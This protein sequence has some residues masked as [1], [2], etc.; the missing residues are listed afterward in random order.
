VA[1]KREKLLE[2]FNELGFHNTNECSYDVIIRQK[3]GD[4]WEFAPLVRAIVGPTNP[5][6]S[7]L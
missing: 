6:G 5:T 3:G 1:K 4:E 7:A 2:C